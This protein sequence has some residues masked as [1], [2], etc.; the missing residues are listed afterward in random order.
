MS[1]NSGL[2]MWRGQC[3]RSLSLSSIVAS[4]SV[5]PSIQA[6]GLVD[7]IFRMVLAMPMSLWMK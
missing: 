5:E 3:V 2:L 4:R 7:Q 6:F 1:L